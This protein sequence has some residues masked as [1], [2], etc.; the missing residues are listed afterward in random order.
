LGLSLHDHR[1]GQ[2]LVAVRHVPNVQ[3]HQ[4][5]ATQ[6]V[7]DRQV[8]HGQIANVMFVRWSRFANRSLTTTR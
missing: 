2:Y 3:I 8:K 6:L 1:S 7:V 5:A 4:I